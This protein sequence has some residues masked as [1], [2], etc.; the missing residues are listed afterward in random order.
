[1]SW[2][3]ADGWVCETCDTYS[4]LTWGLAHG[5]CRCNRCHTQYTMR[6]PVSEGS[7][8]VETP[9]NMLM[10]DYKG[11]AK[12]RYKLCLTPISRWSDDDWDEAFELW[13]GRPGMRKRE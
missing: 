11:P 10:E 8:R 9:I 12:A 13:H 1:M 5:V 3:L 2:P 6:R 7:E 4:G